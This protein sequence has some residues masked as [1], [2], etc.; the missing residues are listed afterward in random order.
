MVSFDVRMIHAHATTFDANDAAALAGFWSEALGQPV[1]PD[2]SSEFTSIGMGEGDAPAG[3]WMFIQVP[4]DKAA[5]N[6]VHVDFAAVDGDLEAEVERL[7][8]LGATR[9]GGQ[10]MPGL[11][12]VTLTDPEGNEFDVFVAAAE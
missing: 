1:D 8:G 10:E 11:T 12:W 2:G 7:V 5:K 4:E 6:R 3:R 9:H